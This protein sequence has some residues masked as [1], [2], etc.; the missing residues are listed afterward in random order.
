MSHE[1]YSATMRERWECAP[2]HATP[3]RY[4]RYWHWIIHPADAAMDH[5]PGRGKWRTRVVSE[6]PDG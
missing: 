2:L 4:E 6:K 5:A 3:T 1:E